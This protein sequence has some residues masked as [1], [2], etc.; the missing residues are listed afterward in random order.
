MAIEDANERCAKRRG[1]DTLLSA[2]CVAIGTH[3]CLK[4]RTNP[5]FGQQQNDKQLPPWWR[6]RDFSFFDSTT[7]R[8]I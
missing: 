8:P 7:G 3:P 2:L 1:I 4:E 6:I 5:F